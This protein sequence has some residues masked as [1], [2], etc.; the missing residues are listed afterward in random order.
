MGVTTTYIPISVAE[1]V[2]L[3]Y[4]RETTVVE[5]HVERVTH[6]DI[7]EMLPEDLTTKPHIDRRFLRAAAW[8]EK[9]S[10]ITV[11]LD[12]DA[13]PYKRMEA[14]QRER[15]KWEEE[16]DQLR[17]ETAD[18][19]EQFNTTKQLREAWPDIVPYLPP[20]VADPE[21]AVKLPVRTTDRLSERLGIKKGA[22]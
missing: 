8:V 9:G 22:K 17:R 11:T 1:K 3:T 2:G 14:A 10:F 4:A 13:G 21:R 5:G 7:G 16:R 6:R 15:E 12:R 20:H 18:L 19:L